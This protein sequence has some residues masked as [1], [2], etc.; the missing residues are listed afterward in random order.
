M[1][2]ISHFRN[3]KEYFKNLYSLGFLSD[4][5]EN[6]FESF[7]QKS[8]GYYQ[9]VFKIQDFCLNKLNHYLINDINLNENLNKFL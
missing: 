8:S 5:Y 3:F 7:Y 9:I 4:L 6:N 2:E 1:K